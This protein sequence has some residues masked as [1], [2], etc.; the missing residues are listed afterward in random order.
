[1][2]LKI[3]IQGKQKRQTN[4]KN[5]KE[6]RRRRIHSYGSVPQMVRVSQHV[7]Y[8]TTIAKYSYIERIG[9]GLDNRGVLVPFPIG[10]RDISLLQSVETGPGAHPASYSVDAGG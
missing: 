9:Y 2:S 5:T 1:V 7:S 10:A 3:N 6:R 4:N 8:A